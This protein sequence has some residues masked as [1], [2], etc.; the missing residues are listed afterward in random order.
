MTSLTAQGCN[1][2]AIRL[3]WVCQL[4]P[5]PS[6]LM[7]DTEELG[8]GMAW[9]LGSTAQA[10]LQ[11]LG[12]VVPTVLQN[13]CST[14]LHLNACGTGFN[15]SGRVL[16]CLQAA[17]RLRMLGKG[18]ALCIAGA[19]E[20]T[21]RVLQSSRGIT[22]REVL[23]WVMG[24]TVSMMLQ[25]V[26]EYANKGLHFVDSKAAAAKGQPLVQQ[27]VYELDAMYGEARVAREV[28]EEVRLLAQQQQQRRQ[29]QQGAATAAAAAAAAAAT[30]AAAAAGL[31][32]A[33]QLEMQQ[34]LRD[35]CDCSAR[36]GQGHMVV[37]SK[38]GC[39]EE[40]E[41]E[42]QKEEEEEEQQQQ[43]RQ[44]RL[45]PHQCPMFVCLRDETVP[46]VC[47]PQG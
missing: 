15:S 39:A 2:Q 17:G 36:H 34:L 8:C 6:S 31:G 37:S 4:L 3:K 25:G 47:V 21:R 46:Y 41:R 18:Q 45:L 5:P 20:V 14:H 44:A 26:M 7:P 35:I 9:A 27:D 29:Q 43:E 23:Q 11:R 30:G 12:P 19:Q 1:W 10:Q 24:N 13:P 40:C 33:E 28:G 22:S 32:A 42:L 38:H 16:A